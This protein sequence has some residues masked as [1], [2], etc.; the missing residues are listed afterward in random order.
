M[1]AV[2]LPCGCQRCVLC[3]DPTMD[4][5]CHPCQ[6]FGKPDKASLVSWEVD[7][8][9]ED[10][11]TDWCRDLLEQ[12]ECERRFRIHQEGLEDDQKQHQ[13]S[14]WVQLGAPEIRDLSQTYERDMKLMDLVSHKWLRVL[15]W[16]CG[17]CNYFRNAAFYVHKNSRSAKEYGWWWGNPNY[18]LDNWDSVN[19]LEK[20]RLSVHEEWVEYGMENSRFRCVRESLDIS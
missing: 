8:V 19:R 17:S 13:R 16:K 9:D 3:F 6:G 10:K 2:V 14:E 11:L 15:P 12:E 4:A 20:L 1:R 7:L 18:G 5:Y